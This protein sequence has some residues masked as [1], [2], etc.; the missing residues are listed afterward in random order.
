M[1]DELRC[2]DC[3]HANPAG[4]TSCARC[5]FPLS[6]P[7]GAES[8]PPRPEDPAPASEPVS[9][10][11]PASGGTSPLPPFRPRRPRPRMQQQ[12]TSLWL[13]F[14]GIAAAVVIYTGVKANID[15]GREPVEGAAPE[16]QQRADELLTVL[17]RD[18]TNIEA[19]IALAD[20]LYDTGNWQQAAVHYSKAVAQ[21]S[22][23]VTALVDLGVCYYNLG[24]GVEAERLFHLALARDPT[25]PVALFNLGI[26]HE[27]RKEYDESLK[28]FHRALASN[29]PEDMKPVIIDA[30]KRLQQATGR[31]PTPLPGN[32]P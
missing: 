18:T 26:L 30:M 10:V 11:A 24:E 27:R 23:R 32:S 20:V 1:S 16:Q 22:T 9:S 4:S 12:A 2:P 8:D 3:G 17:E 31:T 6:A 19:R 21:D 29:P 15:R 28:Y 25:Q 7:V 5:N 13:V 14:A